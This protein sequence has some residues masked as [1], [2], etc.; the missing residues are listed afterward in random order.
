V[1]DRQWKVCVKLHR[2]AS[3]CRLG[4]IDGITVTR[5]EINQTVYRKLI[6]DDN[7]QARLLKGAEVGRYL[8][9]KQLSQGRKEWFDESA[10]LREHKAKAC[11]GMRRIATQR[12]TGVDEKLRIVATVILPQAYFADSTNS[13]CVDPLSQYSLEYVL[14]LLNSAMFQWR[15][16]ITSTN[17][18]VAT[19]ELDSLPFRTINFK[20]PADKSRHDS[21]VELVDRMLGLQKSLPQAKT[22]HEKTLL[23]RQIKTTD[24]QIDNLVYNLYGLTDEEIAIVKGAE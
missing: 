18:N 16:K 1:D 7:S 21:M 4:D 11:V 13:I 15:F 20:D 19:N 3:A 12:I 8:H 5:G 9:R 14:G 10:F 23:E 2:L 17:N 22:D 24:N 6:T